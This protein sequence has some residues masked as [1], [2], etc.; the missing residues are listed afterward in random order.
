[1]PG[2]GDLLEEELPA[3]QEHFKQLKCRA[4]QAVAGI[5]ERRTRLPT[6]RNGRQARQ[7]ALLE[8]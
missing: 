7:A 6:P 3:G 1:M 8:R 5:T 4:R 2:G